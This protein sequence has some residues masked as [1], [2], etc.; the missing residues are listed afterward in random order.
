MLAE[1]IRARAAALDVRA[2]SR[3]TRT[4]TTS[5]RRRS[6]RPR[7]STRSSPR[8]TWPASRTSRR[9]STT[10]SRCTCALLAKPS[11]VVDVTGAYRREAAR[12]GLLPVAVRG[13][14]GQPGHTRCH[15]DVR[16]Q[17]GAR[18]I[19][20]AAGEPFF[21]AEE[22]GVADIAAHAVEREHVERSD[23]D[24]ARK[25]TA[26]S[27]RVPPYDRVGGLHDRERRRRARVDVRR[28]G[29]TGRA[30]CVRGRGARR[31]SGRAIVL[32]ATRGPG[33]DGHDHPS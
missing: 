4:R 1:V 12:A 13:E 28:R 33:R 8:P 25:G 6:A 27:S 21:S 9:S 19:G 3:P 15:A 20:V 16:R 5:R 10:T 26:R 29:S 7:A 11:F 22:I 14:P 24:R 31:S 30:S 32:G 23:A 2:V 18:F 17:A